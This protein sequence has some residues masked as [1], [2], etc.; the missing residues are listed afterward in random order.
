VWLY[1]EEVE[2]EHWSGG[3]FRSND[4]AWEAIGSE[5][6]PACAVVVATDGA[7]WRSTAQGLTRMQGGDPDLVTVSSP[8]PDSAGPDG[9]VWIKTGTALAL[10]HPDGSRTA[11]DLPKGYESFCLQSA[12]P[13]GS[14]WINAQDLQK[15]YEVC[16]DADTLIRWD[17]HRWAA[18]NGTDTVNLGPQDEGDG[19]TMLVTD[20][21][22][23]WAS[24][25]D[26]TIGRYADGQWKV[27]H[28]GAGDWL[29][30]GAPGGRACAFTGWD[31]HAEDDQTTGIVCYD[32]DGEIAR[33]DP[34]VV[35]DLSVSPEGDVW[36]LGD[37][38]ARLPAQLPTT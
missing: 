17:G 26:S 15:D 2:G 27:F 12:G 8:C 37:E 24:L 9:S 36:I 19:T 7:V 23:T 21:G 1:V 5:G 35:Y 38:V 31:I 11:V 6:D 25:T 14:A 3:W 29:L 30:A 4:D 20:D 18:V 16:A 10:I 33:F 34:G 28:P 13:E 32:P 22:A